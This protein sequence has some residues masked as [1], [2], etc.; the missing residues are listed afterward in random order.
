MKVLLVT[1]IFP[2]DAGGPARYVP[3]MASA[4]ARQHEV[5][6]VV[7][8]SDRLDHDDRA[9]GFRVVRIARNQNRQLRR[10]RTV[11]TIAREAGRADVV[12]LNGLVLE[13]KVATRL[14]A[15]RPTVIKVVGD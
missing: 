6:A 13:G 7:T 5:V 1:G 11:R 10:W 3:Q 2:P 14:L 4:L 12:Y 15:R 8:L 9:F